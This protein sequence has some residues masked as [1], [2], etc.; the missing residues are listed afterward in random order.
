MPATKIVGE[1]FFFSLSGTP[2]T[3]TAPKLPARRAST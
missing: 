2:P 3:L 1:V